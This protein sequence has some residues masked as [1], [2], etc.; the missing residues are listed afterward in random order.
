ML[1]AFAKLIRKLFFKKHLSLRQLKHIFKKQNIYSGSCYVSSTY[2]QNISTTHFSPYALDSH[3]NIQTSRESD[4]LSYPC[5]G[6]QIHRHSDILTNTYTHKQTLRHTHIHI[7]RH[8]DIKKYPFTPSNEAHE[9]V[10]FAN[11]TS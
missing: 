5:I 6:I 7:Y 8:I 11:E 4:T 1:L 10:N 2:I 9:V 3:I